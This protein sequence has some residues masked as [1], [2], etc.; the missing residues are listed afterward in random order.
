MRERLNQMEH[1]IGKFSDA[2]LYL[3]GANPSVQKF[4]K[5]ED[6]IGSPDLGRFGAVWRVL[7][8]SEHNGLLARSII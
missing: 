1:Q 2:V 3:S 5:M 8:K 4:R 7:A 6:P